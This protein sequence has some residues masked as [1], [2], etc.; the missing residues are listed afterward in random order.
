MGGTSRAGGQEAASCW[1][2]SCWRRNERASE[3]EKG[4]ERASKSWRKSGGQMA[5]W[6]LV[7]CQLA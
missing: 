7:V 6:F 4:P 2:D 1:L 5:G 3:S